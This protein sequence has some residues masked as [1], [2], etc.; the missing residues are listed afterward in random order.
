MSTLINMQPFQDDSK[1]LW[2]LEK[3]T[4]KHHISNIVKESVISLKLPVVVKQT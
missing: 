3:N 4:I 1:D 2:M